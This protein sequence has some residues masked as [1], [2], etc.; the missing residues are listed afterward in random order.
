M[1]KC[2]PL[3]DRVGSAKLRPREH[4]C[5]LGRGATMAGGKKLVCERIFNSAVRARWDS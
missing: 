4:F 5:C 3:V 2:H 1:L